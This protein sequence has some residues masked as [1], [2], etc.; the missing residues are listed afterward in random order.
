MNLRNKMKKSI[1]F[2]CGI[3][4]ISFAQEPISK[5]HFCFGYT[6]LFGVELGALSEN[7]IPRIP[8]LKFTNK[9]TLGYM[10]PITSNIY[11]HTITGSCQVGGKLNLLNKMLNPGAGL[12]FNAYMPYN[13]F[14]NRME[15]IFIGFGF[16]VG[17]STALK[18]IEPSLILS[19]IHPNDDLKM[20][21][22]FIT[23]LLS[24][25]F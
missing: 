5:T 24:K 1:L 20:S 17:F 14:T 23:L 25:S 21:V 18:G 8:Q 16:Y 12:T 2:I 22:A 13:Q 15:S 4:F 3:V 6:P 19:I 10:I 7:R 9:I 11:S